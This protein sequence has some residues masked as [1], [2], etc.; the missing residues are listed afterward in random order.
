M[1]NV[2]LRFLMV[3]LMVVPLAI[4]ATGQKPPKKVTL[5]GVVVDANQKPVEGAMIFIDGQKTDTETDQKGYYKLKIRPDAKTVSVF[6]LL[7]GS[8]IELPIDGR[9][10]I[11]FKIEA[12]V[13]SSAPPVED[14][15]VINVGYGTVK[16]KDLTVSVNKID[17]QNAKYTSYTDIYEMIR[18]EV[19]GVQVVGKQIWIQGTSTVNL[20]SPLFVVDGII[21][22]S[23]DDIRPSQVK[24]IE[25]LKGSSAS[26]YGTRGANGV[27]LIN[28]MDAAGKK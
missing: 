26:I 25:I 8:V 9:S 21:I 17:G 20:S 1:M 15:E 18:G 2:K 11:N 22:N 7:T 10:I 4:P 24:S 6:T 28:L 27:I 5:S 14:D 19:P 13:Q 16:K 12:T 3:L 23:V